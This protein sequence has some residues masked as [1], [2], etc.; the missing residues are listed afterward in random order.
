MTIIISREYGNCSTT[1]DKLLIHNSIF[2]KFARIA[3]VG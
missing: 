2:K 3:F 1:F